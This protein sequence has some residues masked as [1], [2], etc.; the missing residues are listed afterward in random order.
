MDKLLNRRAALSVGGSA[1]IAAAAATVLPANAAVTEADNLRTSG[2]GGAT[3]LMES[4]PSFQTLF[5]NTRYFEVDSV[6]AGVRFSARVT[7]PAG[8]DGVGTQHF[9]VVYQIDGNLY[10]PATAP[11]HQASHSDVM[12]TLRPFILVSVGYSREES[13]AWIG[14]ACAI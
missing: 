3:G 11:F 10:F 13:H 7:L 6:I 8:Y 2:A 12:S 9:P 4:A 5:P 14:S 1:L